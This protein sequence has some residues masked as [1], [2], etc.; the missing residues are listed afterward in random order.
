MFMIFQ[1][2]PDSL[3]PPLDPHIDNHPGDDL[4]VVHSRPA[5]LWN[6]R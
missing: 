6:V 3:S 4:L 5:R 1:E 2:G